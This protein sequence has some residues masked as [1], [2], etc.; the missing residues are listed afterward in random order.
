MQGES[1]IDEVNDCNC[2]APNENSG[3]VSA[4]SANGYFE[5]VVVEHTKGRMS[6]GLCN[7]GTPTNTDIWLPCGPPTFCWTV[8]KTTSSSACSS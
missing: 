8:N 7:G 3:P 1:K 2:G 6:I 4:Q 5:V